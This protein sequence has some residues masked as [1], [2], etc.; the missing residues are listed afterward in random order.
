MLEIVGPVGWLIGWEAVMLTGNGLLDVTALMDAEWK[1]RQR[2]AWERVMREE[3]ELAAMSGPPSW[4]VLE[5]WQGEGK[6]T[7]LEAAKRLRGK[8][9]LDELQTDLQTAN[10]IRGGLVSESAN[11]LQTS[12]ARHVCKCGEIARP[13]GTDCWKCYRERRRE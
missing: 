9:G 4:M 6:E 5:E 1:G 12:P 13:R 11:T 3:P 2:E 8:M 7:F 10:R